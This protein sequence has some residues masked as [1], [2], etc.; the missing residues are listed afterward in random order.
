M[1]RKDLC[2]I[3]AAET[4]AAFKVRNLSSGELMQVVIARA[5]TVDPHLN[6]FTATFPAGARSVP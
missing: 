3:V 1:T 2:Y 5:G 4:L 6:A